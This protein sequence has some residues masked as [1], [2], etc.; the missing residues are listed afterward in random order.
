MRQL[1]KWGDK[2]NLQ[3]PVV[4][5]FQTRDVTVVI[6]AVPLPVIET[7]DLALPE[8]GALGPGFFIEL[9]FDRINE[10]FGTNS[11]ALAFGKCRVV[12]EV[13]SR[14]DVNRVDQAIGG[15]MWQALSQVRLELIGSGKVLITVER[16]V[17]VYDNEVGVNVGGLRR[18]K[19]GW[20]AIHGV[21][22]N[23]VCICAV[24]VLS[25]LVA[26]AQCQ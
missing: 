10:V 11:A 15:Y 18:V 2:L 19:T 22:V 9:S 25:M 17:E 7:H 4:E 24:L 26:C 6:R 13:H 3:S 16:V 5:R 12:D 20:C 21:T 14:L 8:P 23:T 1:W